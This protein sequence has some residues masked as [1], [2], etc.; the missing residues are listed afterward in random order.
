MIENLW[1]VL[2]CYKWLVYCNVFVQ[3]SAGVIE[4]IP[5]FQT[6]CELLVAIS[7]DICRNIYFVYERCDLICKRHMSFSIINQY[8]QNPIVHRITSHHRYSYLP[9]SPL[10]VYMFRFTACSTDREDKGI[11]THGTLPRAG[12]YTDNR[13][14]QLCKL[15]QQ[16][17]S[18]GIY[19]HIV[20]FIY[21][22]CT[23]VAKYST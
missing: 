19:F 1:R 3:A 7:T 17:A 2:P 13:A 12:N 16:A 23:S 6:L 8:P 15:W 18:A 14:R 5:R 11:Q 9:Y 20:Y 22:F 4:T 21:Y 10:H